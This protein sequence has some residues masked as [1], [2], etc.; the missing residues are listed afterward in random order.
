VAFEIGWRQGA[1]VTAMLESSNFA[2]V[3]ITRDLAGRDRVV[4]GQSRSKTAGLDE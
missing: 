4:L 3:F 1:A 2:S